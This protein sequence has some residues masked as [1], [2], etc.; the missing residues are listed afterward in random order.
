MVDVGEKPVTR[1]RATA[2]GEIQL[3]AAAAAV[4][5]EGA[6]KGDVF[7]AARLAGIAAAKR[8]AEWIPLCHA[9]PLDK[10]QVDFSVHEGGEGNEGNE[11]GRRI[12]CTATAIA[13]A[14]T[15]VEMEALVAVSAALLT[16]YDMLKAADKGMVMGN[17]RL[18]HKAGGA[19]GEFSRDG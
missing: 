7:A 8:T 1:R 6:P 3:S 16:L 2:A 12:E 5:S 14:K 19:S 9:L 4:L 17:V 18:L 13:T 15:G 10:V 11:G